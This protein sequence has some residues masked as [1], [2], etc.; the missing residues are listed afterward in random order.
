MPPSILN[1]A[2][3][4]DAA[5]RISQI[6]SQGNS[7]RREGFS[8]YNKIFEF[9]YNIL[10]NGNAPTS[11]VFQRIVWGW[12]AHLSVC[13]CLL[14]PGPTLGGWVMNTRDAYQASQ[15][16]PGSISWIVRLS[17]IF[18]ILLPWKTWK[19]SL[20]YLPRQSSRNGAIAY[21]KLQR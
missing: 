4:N 20:V 19:R 2:E 14:I 16:C 7:H 1:V 8:V 10:G 13:Q 6:L 12:I 9:D 5:K 18:P 15:V 17:A 11:I 3:K 21:N